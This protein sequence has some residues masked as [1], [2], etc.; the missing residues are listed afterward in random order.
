MNPGP[1]SLAFWGRLFMAA[2]MV[3][4]YFVQCA[5]KDAGIVD[6]G[7]AGGNGSGL[8]PSGAPG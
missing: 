6:V 7:W 4:L 1:F 8:R 5:R 2:V 3:F